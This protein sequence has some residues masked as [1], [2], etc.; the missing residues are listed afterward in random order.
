MNFVIKYNNVVWTTKNWCLAT[1]HQSQITKW[2]TSIF[3]THFL[4]CT[5]CAI[6]KKSC[7]L[8]RIEKWSKI[9]H[10]LDVHGCMLAM[11]AQTI[12]RKTISDTFDGISELPMM[13]V[14]ICTMLKTPTYCVI[15]FHL[16]VIVFFS[17]SDWQLW[18]YMLNNPQLYGLL[19][20]HLGHAILRIIH[21]AIDN[22][23][24]PMAQLFN[25]LWNLKSKR[26]IICRHT[27]YT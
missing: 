21:T 5:G 14:S 1:K 12:D 4:L 24:Q 11:V 18:V 15:K 7:T 8:L 22:Y 19:C 26:L 10:L 16:T 20:Q 6:T 3:L 17:L 13:L 2:A 25:Y 23:N 27:I 9:C